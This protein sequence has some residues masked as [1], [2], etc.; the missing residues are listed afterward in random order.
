MA[1]TFAMPDL[2]DSGVITP[3]LA[4]ADYWAHGAAAALSPAVICHADP[5]PAPP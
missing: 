3:I 4:R 5:S 2:I 1:A